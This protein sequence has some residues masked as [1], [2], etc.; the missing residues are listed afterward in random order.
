[1]CVIRFMITMT[2][3]I[4]DHCF[5]NRYTDGDQELDYIKKDY[6]TARKNP[7]STRFKRISS[8]FFITCKVKLATTLKAKKFY[9]CHH[10][11]DISFL[12]KNKIYFLARRTVV[13][14]F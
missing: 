4:H 11:L 8:F 13:G 14:Y 9:F 12:P 6:N 10:R 2:L 3:S 1:M 7:Y 5:G